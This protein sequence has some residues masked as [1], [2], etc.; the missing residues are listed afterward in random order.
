MLQS[1]P[2]KAVLFDLDGTLHDRPTSLRRFI[3]AQYHRIAELRV[4]PLD[5]WI[6]HFVVV[7]NRGLVWKDIVYQTLLQRF[8]INYPWQ[9]LLH[10]YEINFA[11]SAQ[12]Y[13]G[14]IELLCELRARQIAIGMITNGRT[15]FQQSVI[16]ALGFEQLF[17]VILISQA[18]GVA[19]P[20]PEIFQRA[21]TRLDVTAA[22]T[23]F[24]GDSLE[25]DMA[26]AKQLGMHTIWKSTELVCPL[27]CSDHILDD[28][29]AIA[30]LPLLNH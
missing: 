15:E 18:E 13:S 26:G 11:A 17:D 29:I 12:L 8:G 23:V 20:T 6:E 21:L 19:K 2:V 28:M 24:V 30:L 7:D 1:I 22:E 16:R 25:A 10:D 27:G 14:A 3:A 4:I 9:A 5:Q